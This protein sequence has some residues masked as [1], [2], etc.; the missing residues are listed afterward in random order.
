V[1]STRHRRTLILESAC[2][3]MVPPHGVAPCSSRLS[4]EDRR[5]VKEHR[6]YQDALTVDVLAR[7]GTDV[8]A[9]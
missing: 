9:S 7:D 3:N 1:N 5:R 8:T 4:I 2:T 6:P